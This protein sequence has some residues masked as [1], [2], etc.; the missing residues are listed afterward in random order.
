MYTLK[1]MKK[2]DDDDFDNEDIYDVD[3]K[4]VAIE[5]QKAS[6]E[7]KVQL[8]IKFNHVIDC[9]AVVRSVLSVLVWYY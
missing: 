8:N 1:Q 9:I 6:V 4:L 5:D 7:K 2:M 3:K